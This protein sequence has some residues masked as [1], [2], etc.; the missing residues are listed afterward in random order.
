MF[1]IVTLEENNYF[2]LDDGDNAVAVDVLLQP[3]IEGSG[4]IS[5]TDSDYSDGEATGATE[6]LPSRV[7]QQQANKA[8]RCTNANRFEN[9]AKVKKTKNNKQNRKGCQ[10]FIRC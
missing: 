6:H 8:V 9:I 2:G 1:S 10:S 5:D 4:V 7:L 3:Q